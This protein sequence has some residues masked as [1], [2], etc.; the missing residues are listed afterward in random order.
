MNNQSDLF[1]AVLK[2]HAQHEKEVAFSRV[3]PKCGKFWTERS[4]WIAENDLIGTEDK[5]M[6]YKNCGINFVTTIR[7]T[8]YGHRG[9]GGKMLDEGE[10]L[11][12]K[13][14]LK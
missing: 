8:I 2:Y 4:I 1:R 7:V 13:R 9:C 14:R 5:L 11:G 10:S 6:N 3:C 12:S